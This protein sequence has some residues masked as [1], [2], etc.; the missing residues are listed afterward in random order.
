M[1]GSP[2]VLAGTSK[3]Q[4]VK[5]FSPPF[6]EF[7]VASVSIAAGDKIALPV[8]AGPQLLLIQAGGGTASATPP[9]GAI[10]GSQCCTDRTTSW[11]WL[12]M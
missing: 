5:V 7:E 6:D 3:A 11:I 10:S 1:Q 12:R 8:N 2:D 4:G 9:P